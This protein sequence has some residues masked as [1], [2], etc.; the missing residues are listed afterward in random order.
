[1]PDVLEARLREP[2]KL[3][4][5]QERERPKEGKHNLGLILR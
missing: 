2:A 5:D 1:M 4:P 3:V